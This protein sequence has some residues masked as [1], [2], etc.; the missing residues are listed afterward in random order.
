MPPG[1]DVHQH[2]PHTGNRLPVD[3]GVRVFV[4][5]I[6]PADRFTEDLQ[7][8]NDGV[9]QGVRAKYGI[10]AWSRIDGNS[11]DTFQHVRHIGTL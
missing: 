4:G 8:T 6:N 3:F 5:R 9:L 7:I 2:V 10:A 1:S 11:A